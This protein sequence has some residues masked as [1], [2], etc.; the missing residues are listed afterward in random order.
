MVCPIS[1]DKPYAK[2]FCDQ[3]KILF[4]NRFWAFHN[5]W[6][7]QQQQCTNNHLF[8]FLYGFYR[9]FKDRLT[10]Q[11]RRGDRNKI[12]SASPR[13]A[14]SQSLISTPALETYYHNRVIMSTRF[15]ES[16]CVL[17]G[18]FIQKRYSKYTI[19]ILF[20]YHIKCQF[21]RFLERIKN[22]LK[23]KVD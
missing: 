6:S 23:I 13:W 16:I 3:K 18:I 15:T 12:D 20:I 8:S 19:K 10:P 9:F 2:N 11:K 14:R 21:N 1:P 4:R 7:S 5:Q 22:F 17:T